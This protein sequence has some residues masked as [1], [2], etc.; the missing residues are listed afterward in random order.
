MA[1]QSGSRNEEDASSSVPDP[2]E[3]STT[4]SVTWT[5]EVA[6]AIQPTLAQKAAAKLVAQVPRTRYLLVL[7]HGVTDDVIENVLKS[8]QTHGLTCQMVAGSGD[9]RYVLVT[10]EFKVLAAQVI[11]K[12]KALR[13]N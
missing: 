10:A 3:L 7:D 2:T 11:K 6:A 8:L 12:V 5:K 1:A 9:E 4:T 13:V